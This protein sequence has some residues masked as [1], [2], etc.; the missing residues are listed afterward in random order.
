MTNTIGKNLRLSR[1]T[2]KPRGAKELHFRRFKIFR[3]LNKVWRGSQ[4]SARFQGFDRYAS[5]ER[6]PASATIR[7]K[8]LHERNSEKSDDRKHSS[9]ASF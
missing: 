7:V 9:F 6:K 1:A 8:F 2:V 3:K 4:K 5:T